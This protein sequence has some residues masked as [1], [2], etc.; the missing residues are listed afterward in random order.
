MRRTSVA[1]QGDDLADVAVDTWRVDDPGGVAS[2]QVQVRLMRRSGAST[3]S[4]SVDALHAVA[5]R[6]P[7]GLPSVS[8]PGPAAGITLDVPRY[9]QMSHTGH[10]PA[11]R[12]RRRGLVLPHL[13]RRWCSATTAR[14]PPRRTYAWVG[15]GHTDPWVD[16]AARATYDAAYEGTGN[17]PFNTAFAA[18][19]AGDAF[20]T[21]LRGPARRRAL[22]RG[23][24]PAGGLGVLRE[25]RAH[26][27]PDLRDRRAT[28][29]S[30][31]ASPSPATW[32][33]TTPPHAARSGVRRT[34][35]RAELEAAWL[36]GS[37]GVVYVI[38]DD[39]HA[40]PRR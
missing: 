31:S 25:R 9:S 32:S 1:G 5:T 2:Y 13:D 34:Y 29:S 24:H 12:R 18:S 38:H 17:W 7:A 23:R 8:A 4:P 14:C 11:V 15:A 26:R 10:S 37:G 20:V 33:S 19:L 36:G 6:L 35:D 40:L 3:P 27:R 28:C 16:Q 21:R 22:H 39:A 30:S